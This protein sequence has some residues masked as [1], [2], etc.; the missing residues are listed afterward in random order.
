MIRRG[1]ACVEKNVRCNLRNNIRTIKN[2]DRLMVWKYWVQNDSDLLSTIYLKKYLYL[3]QRQSRYQFM[4]QYNSGHKNAR[5]KYQCSSSTQRAG[6]SKK[7]RVWNRRL[8]NLT[9]RPFIHTHH[10]GRVPRHDPWRRQCWNQHRTCQT[11]PASSVSYSWSLSTSWCCSG[12]TP[13]CRWASNGIAVSQTNPS[14]LHQQ[15]NNQSVTLAISADFF[16]Q[17]SDCEV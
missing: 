17:T 15:C 9:Q 3:A 12:R 11:A 4:L 1:A 2:K 8:P 16:M 13:R 7:C 5:K 10:W 14:V 6:W